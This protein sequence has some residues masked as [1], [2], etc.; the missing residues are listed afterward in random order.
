[1]VWLLRNTSST[2]T[3]VNHLPY[4]EYSRIMKTIERQLKDEDIRRRN[5]ENNRK[6]PSDNI[7]KQMKQWMSKMSSKF[8]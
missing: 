4:F 3:E 7:G 2:I 1:M 6:P 8:K 5:E